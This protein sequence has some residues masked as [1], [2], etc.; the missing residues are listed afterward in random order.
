MGMKFRLAGFI[1]AVALLAA[2]TAPLH[3]QEAYPSRPVKIMIGFPVGGLIDIVA[4][5][6]GDKLAI[7][8]DKP[9]IIEARPGATGTLATASVARADPDGYT[10]LLV[11]DNH[12][13]NPSLMKNVPY[14][15]LRDFASIGFIG[16]VP[17]IFSASTH[18]PHRAV[19]S[20]IDEAHA[21]PGTVTYASIG[22]GSG[23]HLAGETLASLANVTLQHVP[24]R[25]GPAAVND[26][27]AGHVNTMV[28][29]PV[30][31]LQL[32]RSG[33]IN[34][35]AAASDKRL[36]VLPDLPTMAE[37]GYPVEAYSWM[38]L[39]APAGT[40]A[41]IVARLEKALAD[42]LA[43]P[44]V[45][46]RLVDMGALVEPLNGKQFEDYVRKEIDRWKEVTAKIGIKPE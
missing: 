7:L 11:N 2:G 10:L 37:M 16:R 15:S 46:Q 42:V 17:M 27:V 20:V 19:Q 36:E 39:V 44:D 34:A 1:V 35:I 31:A 22:V 32:I 38:G 43:M 40:P 3:A 26:L 45:R 25:G 6:V 5:I 12:A 30:I 33:K 13:L 4:R 8:L 9:F 18:F 41:P 21:K 28:L 29:S 14:D 23:S 24:Y